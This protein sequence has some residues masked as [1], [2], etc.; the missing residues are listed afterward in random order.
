METSTIDS[1]RNLTESTEIKIKRYSTH[2]QIA[3]AQASL[4][5]AIDAIA[6]KWCK[7]DSGGKHARVG[8]FAAPERAS[9]P[10]LIYPKGT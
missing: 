9:S 1:I 4:R 5:Q 2:I 10:H 7:R 8:G 6:G 3:Y